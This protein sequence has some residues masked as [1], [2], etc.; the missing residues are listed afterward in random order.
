M[1]LFQAVV[2]PSGFRTSVQPC[3]WI[4][5]W[6]W[7]LQSSTQ[8]VRLV[9]PPSALC[10][11]W[12]TWQA[13]AGWS[14]PPG[15]VQHASPRTPL[16][17]SHGRGLARNLQW[18]GETPQSEPREAQ[19]DATRHDPVGDRAPRRRRHVRAARRHPRAPTTGGAPP[20][21]GARPGG[22]ARRQARADMDGRP[23]RPAAPAL[24]CRPGRQGP[25][26]GESAGGAC[27]T[28]GT[29]STAAAGLRRR[30]GRSWR[31]PSW[32]RAAAEPVPVT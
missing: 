4:A 29:T 6:W 31:R 30:P 3:R 21:P 26:D 7:K 27:A 1:S 20:L 10:V 11:A 25:G 18:E 16:P 24:P 22:A 15:R 28:A 13:A 23:R 9:L 12:W 5:T 2:V 32:R 8:S 19:M 17:P 14:H